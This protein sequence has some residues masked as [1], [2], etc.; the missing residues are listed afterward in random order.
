L[1]FFEPQRDY[2]WAVEKA[3]GCGGLV[4]P[5]VVVICSIFPKTLKGCKLWR[6]CKYVLLWDIFESG[7]KEWSPENVPDII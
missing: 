2:C 4:F 6:N 5:W 1:T 3:Q 7:N